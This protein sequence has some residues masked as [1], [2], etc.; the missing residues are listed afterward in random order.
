[1]VLFDV[2]LESLP[3]MVE[4]KRHQGEGLNEMFWPLVK[5]VARFLLIMLL[6]LLLLAATLLLLAVR[7]VLSSVLLCQSGLSFGDHLI[8][9]GIEEKFTK[10]VCELAAATGLGHD[11]SWKPAE[12]LFAWVVSLFGLVEEMQLYSLA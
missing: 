7:F 4:A 12:L 10:A 11:Q 5:Q 6:V 2:Y 9:S 1:M 8:K 3:A